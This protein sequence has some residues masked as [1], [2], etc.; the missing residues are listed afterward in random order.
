LRVARELGRLQ[1][2]AAALDD[3][4]LTFSHV[5]ALT[6]VATPKTEDTWLERAR[7][8]TAAQVEELVRGR[9]PGDD[10]DHPPRPELETR[11]IFLEVSPATF[12]LHRQRRQQADVEC[13]GKLTDD[14]FYDWLL[15]GAPAAESSATSL[16][17][18]R[19]VST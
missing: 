14:Q 8:K 19:S 2:V 13:G 11:R 17:V 3:G 16:G 1:Q 18:V 15:R 6:R 5:R 12:A 7:G 10:P 4:E 9:R